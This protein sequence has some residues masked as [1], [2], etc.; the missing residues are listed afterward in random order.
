MAQTDT[1]H[2]YLTEILLLFHGYS[3]QIWLP[4]ACGLC[5]RLSVLSCVLGALEGFSHI[6]EDISCYPELFDPFVAVL[7]DLAVNKLFPQAIRAGLTQ[8]LGQLKDTITKTEKLRQPLRMR[9]KKPAPIKQF[10]PKFEE[11]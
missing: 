4:D 9:V 6:Y 11:E 10:N 7:Q 2:F 8:L 3:K 1:G 5:C